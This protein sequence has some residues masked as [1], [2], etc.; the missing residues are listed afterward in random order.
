[1][2]P[3]KV[4]LICLFIGWV[5][6]NYSQWTSG[7]NR[8]FQW[9]ESSSEQEGSARI[10]TPPPF[11]AS[12]AFM[13]INE[14]LSISKKVQSDAKTNRQTRRIIRSQ[15]QFLN[16]MIGRI[17]EDLQKLQLC[18]LPGNGAKIGIDIDQSIDSL[19]AAMQ[20]LDQVVS[21][22]G[23]NA[24][25]SGY[26]LMIGNAISNMK[27]AKINIAYITDAYWYFGYLSS[28]VKAVPAARNPGRNR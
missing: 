5:L 6:L 17:I 19:K 25:G 2:S 1:M 12:D 8:G 4:L 18:A 13:F 21:D 23:R 10:P 11:I 9:K 7:G 3:K 26:A 22:S 27:V 20:K 28:D 24:S 15:V 14:A 16:T